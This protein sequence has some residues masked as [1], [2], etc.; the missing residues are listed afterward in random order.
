ME[1]HKTYPKPQTLHP[2]PLNHVQAFGLEVS[3]TLLNRSTAPHKGPS[4]DPNKTPINP[5]LNAD[6]DLVRIPSFMLNPKPLNPKPYK[7]YKP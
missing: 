2:K 4:K 5:K 3:Q 1:P 6:P 7:P